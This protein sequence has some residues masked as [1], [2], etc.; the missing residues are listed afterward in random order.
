MGPTIPVNFLNASAILSRGLQ[1]G[2]SLAEIRA[3]LPVIEAAGI[4][5]L[6]HPQVAL[7]DRFQR[8][9][10][11][12]TG[13]L[14]TLSDALAVPPRAT[15]FR[16]QFRFIEE[17]GPSREFLLSVWSGLQDA[18]VLRGHETKARTLANAALVGQIP[19]FLVADFVWRQGAID[20]GHGIS[21]AVV[22]PGR[23]IEI[24]CQKKD[25]DAADGIN[26][27][28]VVSGIEKILGRPLNILETK[29]ETVILRIP[30]LSDIQAEARKILGDEAVHFRPIPGEIP[31]EEVHQDY[32]HRR[33]PIG[34][35][36]SPVY[37]RPFRCLLHPFLFAAHDLFHAIDVASTDPHM[38][39]MIVSLRGVL[40][41]LPQSLRALNAVRLQTYRL[42]E[43][44]ELDRTNYTAFMRS[45][46][47]PVEREIRYAILL[48]DQRRDEN[49]EEGIR[50]YLD[51]VFSEWSFQ[52]PEEAE[53]MV[54][55][56]RGALECLWENLKKRA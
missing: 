54:E 49:L 5:A 40:S 18:G 17:N 33:Q 19:A 39:E 10:E 41:R 38:M 46:F 52:L 14:A 6:F 53:G 23:V 44:F 37:F 36:L 13:S 4:P 12:E 31:P 15:H 26:L 11:L 27:F 30:P 2:Q 35:P 51:L 8:G 24:E 45:L 42:T 32:A 1:A 20:F 48:K 56:A 29:G 28:F 43:V 50:Q 34:L 47:M 7:L 25:Y 16:D 9:E 22:Q 55:T 21:G 3:S